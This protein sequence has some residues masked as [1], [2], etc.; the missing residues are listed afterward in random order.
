MSDLKKTWKTMSNYYMKE[1]HEV[2]SQEK[3]KNNMSDL[4]PMS[5]FWLEKSDLKKMG[6]D[7]EKAS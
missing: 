3:L 6:N 2:R 1:R 5:D 7:G 4:C